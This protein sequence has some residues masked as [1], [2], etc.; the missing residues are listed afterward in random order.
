MAIYSQYSNSEKLKK[1]I[2]G[3]TDELIFDDV[4]FDDDYLNIHTASTEGL[5]NWGLILNQGRSVRS[6]EAYDGIFGFDTG[7]IPPDDKQY[8]QNFNHGTF[9]NEL[10]C[11]TVDLNNAQYRGVLFLLHR[12][13]TI[14]NSLFYLNK[15][16]QEYENISHTPVRGV[17]YVKQTGFCEITYVFPYNLDGYE[18]QLFKFAETLPKPAGYAITILIN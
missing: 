13:Y 18:I 16:I 12:K 8:P 3:I 6:Y 11:P 2:N 10:Y 9:F 5:N 17:P 1:L 4:Q 15:A 7:T 14:N